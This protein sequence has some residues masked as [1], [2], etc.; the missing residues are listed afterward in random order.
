M[1]ELSSMTNSIVAITFMAFIVL[2]LLSVMLAMAI[3]YYTP[4]EKFY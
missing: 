3:Y 4:V 2:C 1:K